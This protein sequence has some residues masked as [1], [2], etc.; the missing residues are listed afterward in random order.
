[1]T[2]KSK[3]RITREN[4]PK[5]LPLGDADWLRQRSCQVVF[6]ALEAGGYEA[7]AVGGAVRNTL[8]RLPVADVDIATPA[9]PGEVSELAKSAG[10]D[11]H[12][13]GIAHGTLTIVSLGVAYEVTTLRRD[14]S[15]DGRRA[16]V[17]F[18]DDWLEDAK[19]RDFTINAIYCD[20][21][22][23]LYDPLRGCEDIAQRRVRFIGSAEQRIREDY[24][25]ILRF[26]RFFAVYS[27][28]AIDATGAA[29]CEKERDGITQLSGER[30]R[31]ELLKLLV[32]PR[33]V[34]AL[35]VMEQTSI[36]MRS[37]EQVAAVSTLEKLVEIERENGLWPDSIR[38]LA[39]LIAP[40]AGCIQ[41]L[42]HRL[43][44][45]NAEGKQLSN[46]CRG[47]GPDY[48]T[49]VLGAKTGLYKYGLTAYRDDCLI[50][51]ARSNA[52]PND[53]DWMRALQIAEDWQV[54]EMPLKGSDLLALGVPAGPDVGSILAEFEQ[55]WIDSG[56]VADTELQRNKLNG[57]VAKFGRAKE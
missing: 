17:A 7:R 52:R 40:K 3:S 41:K 16:T 8:M 1:M 4:P 33:A 46:A 35:K 26:F 53:P 30:I 29:A 27:D 50:S 13:T 43:R 57:L 31:A 45:S 19:R 2:D 34:D 23:K 18:T 51:W 22:G 15:T 24:L 55:W 32:A 10:L 36:L 54:P 6:E 56:F 47:Q 12:E 48:K 11:V 21:D 39:A 14:V 5:T 37:L 44:L 20:R 9:R 28:S 42:A 25:R 38:R 49:S